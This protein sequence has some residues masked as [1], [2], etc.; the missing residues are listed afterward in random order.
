MDEKIAPDLKDVTQKVFKG[1]QQL[2]GE[3]IRLIQERMGEKWTGPFVPTPEQMTPM[4]EVQAPPTQIKVP[5]PPVAVSS[6]IETNTN[7]T[8]SMETGMTTETEQVEPSMAPKPSKEELFGNIDVL[9]QRHQE[10]EKEL[11]NLDVK[12]KERSEQQRQEKL[13][14]RNIR[15]QQPKDTG[16]Q[17]QFPENPESPEKETV[18]NENA[19]YNNA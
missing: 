3:R 15:Q 18:I 1:R 6:T 12:E 8:E 7:P 14:A 2:E 4:P 9:W 17:D 5:Q 10:E 16:R 19:E 11:E 13:R